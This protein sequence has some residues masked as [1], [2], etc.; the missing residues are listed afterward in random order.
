MNR[1]GGNVD[2]YRLLHV[3]SL[4]SFYS[5]VFN[6]VSRTS[7]SSSEYVNVYY[8]LRTETINCLKDASKL[9]LNNSTS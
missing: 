2:K 6:T 4:I 5:R 3:K 1:L 9:V 8:I 7:E